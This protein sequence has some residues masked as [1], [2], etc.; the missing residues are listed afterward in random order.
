[1]RDSAV[2]DAAIE[3]YRSS[4]EY[5]RGNQAKGFLR[6]VARQGGMRAE[7]F[8]LEV[9][10]DE[11]LGQALQA[12]GALF[13]ASSLRL[14][15]EFLERVRSAQPMLAEYLAAELAAQGDAA[16]RAE[17]R[18]VRSLALYRVEYEQALHTPELQIE[19]EQLLLGAADDNERERIEEAFAAVRYTLR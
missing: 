15:V 7:E 8:L 12:V 2:V 10:D 19:L 9:L 14:T 13:E 1:M 18:E 4:V 3:A 16:L 17:Q 6:L 11:P 5:G